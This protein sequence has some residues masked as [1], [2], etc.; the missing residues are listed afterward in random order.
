MDILNAFST[1]FIHWLFR[2]AEIALTKTSD[3]EL[4]ECA[5]MLKKLASV[6]P[7]HISTPSHSPPSSSL[8]F[9]SRPWAK[10]PWEVRSWSPKREADL[11]SNQ[12]FS[13]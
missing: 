1:S 9:D 10:I 12:C 6:H 8:F 4:Q 7:F 3:S 11:G 2:P 5:S 13:L